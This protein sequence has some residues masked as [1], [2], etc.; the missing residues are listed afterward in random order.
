MTASPEEAPT[1][2]S[3][4]YFNVADIQEGYEALRARGVEFTH[5]PHVIHSTNDY[6]LWMAFFKDSEG[7]TMA[8]MDER[9]TLAT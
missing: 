4:L 5:E 2:N 6:E 1:G 9:G 8:I 7:N 3:V